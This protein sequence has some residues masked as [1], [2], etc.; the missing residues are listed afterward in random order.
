MGQDYPLS[1]RLSAE[2]YL[3]GGYGIQDMEAIVNLFVQAGIDMIHASFGTPASPG[4]IVC[5]SIEHPAGFSADLAA[6]IKQRAGVPVIAVGRF[7]RLEQAQ[8]VLVREE[9]D[10]IAFGRQHL[11]DP[12]FFK[13]ALKGR[14][15]LTFE[16][17]ACNQGCIRHLYLGKGI[18]CAINPV[19]GQEMIYPATSSARPRRVLVV[20]RT[21]WFKCGL[22][23]SSPGT[24][25]IAAGAGA[26][27]GR[28]DPDRGQSPLQRGLW[29]MA[30]TAGPVSGQA[31]ATI[32]LG[33][34]G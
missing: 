28:A 23:G 18:R 29:S 33:V 12:D 8:A 9:A 30:G 13:N 14:D 11:A 7:T 21:G 4:G 26:G 31:G 10:L 27:V 17:L 5:P 15:D 2:E 34:K 24:S 22:A 1:L 19:T 3:P 6:R 16:C 20:G 32:K 25:G